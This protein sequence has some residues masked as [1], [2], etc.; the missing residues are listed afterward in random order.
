MA[1]LGESPWYF[2]LLLE[3]INSYRVPENPEQVMRILVAAL[4]S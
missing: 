3:G 2:L 1:V 4:R